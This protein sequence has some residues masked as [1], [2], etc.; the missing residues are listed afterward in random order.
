M[1][2]V[3]YHLPCTIDCVPCLNFES[4]AHSHGINSQNTLLEPVLNM[5][6]VGCFGHRRVYC[7]CDSLPLISFVHKPW[8]NLMLQI[9]NLYDELLSLGNNL[10]RRIHIH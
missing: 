3:N 10:M 4:C 9:S 8:L 1:Q 2:Y 6:T 7:S 5:Y